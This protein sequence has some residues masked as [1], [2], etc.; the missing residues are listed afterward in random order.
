MGRSH[1]TE[2][3]R[4]LPTIDESCDVDTGVLVRRLSDDRR[5]RPVAPRGGP[6]AVLTRTVHDEVIPRL[7]MAR[8]PQPLARAAAQQEQP[9]AEQVDQLVNMVLQGTQTEVTAYVEMMRDSGVP[10]ESLL[11]DLLTPCARTLGQM[12]EDDTC[13]FSDVTLGL[14]RLANVMRLLGH[15][16][17]GD[18]EQQRAGPSALLV[19]MPGE[20]HGFGLAMVAQFFRRAGWNVRQ[21]PMVTSADLIGLVQNHW[22]G[23][24]G[25]SVACSDRIEA[26]A[27]DIRAI[28]RHSRNRSIGVMVGGPPFLAHPQLA[29]MVGA[30]ATAADARQAVRQ[31]QNLIS[32]LARDQ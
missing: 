4:Q 6:R 1:A 8:L 31:A 20:Q 9:R 21:E 24:T 15:A 32:L 23:I 27:A 2:P 17:S 7:L 18:C 26:L 19:Q 25:I 22:F 13:T 28:R 14:V 3:M 10:T 5:S 12:W 16:F 11:L 29:N 30:D